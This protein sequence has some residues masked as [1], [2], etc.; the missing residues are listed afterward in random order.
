MNALTEGYQRTI[1]YLK[2]SHSSSS[3]KNVHEVL[4]DISTADP[5]TK[6]FESALSYEID[7]YNK[8]KRAKQV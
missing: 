7:R 5:E 4:Q 3:V 2:S 1:E 6:R 8:V